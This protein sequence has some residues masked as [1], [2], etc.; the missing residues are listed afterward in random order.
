MRDIANGV[1]LGFMAF[2]V[3]LMIYVMSTG[4]L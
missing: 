2:T 4:G 3:P 1:F